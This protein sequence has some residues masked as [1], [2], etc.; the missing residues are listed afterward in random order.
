MR[1]TLVAGI[2][3]ALGWILGR[4]FPS[5]IASD[6]FMILAAAIAGWP[7]ANR[8]WQALRFRVLG[9]PAL[10]TVA[11]LGAIAIG[12]YWEAAVVTFLFAFGS[13]LEARTLAKT[14]G[15]LREL[16]E[17]AP[18]VARVKKEDGEVEIPA[19]EVEIGT[20]VVVRSGEKIPV[21]GQVI[22]GEATVNQAAITGESVPV[23]KFVGDKVF[24]GTINEA[25]YLV[26][27]RGRWLLLPRYLSWPA[28][29]MLPAMEF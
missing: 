21:D 11:A 23:E 25:G 6:L 14:R 8:A 19:A 20:V 22:S 2:L 1:R 3:I 26:P 16:L 13:Y 28:S 7:I 29:V 10:V 24:G 5:S 15:A 12:E 9:I 27:A 18:Q 4:L 17:L